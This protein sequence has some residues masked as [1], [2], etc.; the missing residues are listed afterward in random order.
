MTQN[1]SVVA[2]F[3]NH[4][5]AESA[6]KELQKSGFDM[7]KLSIVGKDYE[8]EEHVT[9]YYNLGER[10]ATW[11]K[12]GAFWGWIWGCFFGSAFLFVPGLGPVM[13]GGPLVTWLISA[14]ETSVVVGGLSALGGALVGAGVPKDSVVK[15]ESELNA[16]KFLVLAHGTEAEVAS[17]KSILDN[18]DA[19]YSAIHSTP[20]TVLV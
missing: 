11:G 15:Y 19:E 18:N 13:I 17:A 16:H 9:G 5:G 7:K 1:N 12:A 2:I 3:K 14:L 8:T 20:V 6:I 4:S 10:A